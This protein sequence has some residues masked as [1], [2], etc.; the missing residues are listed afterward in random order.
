MLK[1]NCVLLAA[2]LF[3]WPATAQQQNITRAAVDQKQ[4][5]DQFKAADINNDGSLD[6][7]E[8]GNAQQTLP[9]A[10]ASKDRVSRAEFMT[11]C[12]KKD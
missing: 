2:V 8:I 4:C 5:A 7:T 6:R 11:T 3:T 1:A 10:L 9:A 12:S